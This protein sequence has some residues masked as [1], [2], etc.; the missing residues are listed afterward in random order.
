MIR[1]ARS[2]SGCKERGPMEPDHLL[3]LYDREQRIEL[4][5][6]GVKKLINGPVV[7]YLRPPPGM[8]WIG[9]SRLDQA[10]AD[11]IIREEIAYF[12]QFD[13]P[14]TWKVYDHDTPVDLAERLQ[15]HGFVADDPG[16][17]MILDLN[18]VSAELLRPPAADVRQIDDS[19]L[20]EVVRIEQA[21]WGG[22]FGWLAGRLGDHLRVPGYLSICIA[23][24]DGAPASAG[25]LYLHPDSQ[26]AGLFG[27]STIAG[28]R[29]RGLYTALLAVRV[30]QARERG[31]RYLTLEP[32][33]M[34]AG[35]AIRYGFRPVTDVVDYV[36]AGWGRER[37]PSVN[38][39]GRFP[40]GKG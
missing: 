9:Y 28:Y 1:N 39:S 10:G 25:W 3:A 8:N 17:L 13:Q 18:E 15:A 29:R 32:T 34:S 4:T 35:I 6:P 38:S 11:A 20:G 19:Q 16:P 26:F 22:D 36:Y 30:Q 21:V 14:F 7:R 40:E 31:Y 2:M 5:I 12:R 33:A 24:S 23:Y 27:G 37:T